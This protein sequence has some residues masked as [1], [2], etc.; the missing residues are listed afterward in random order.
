MADD[1]VRAE[2]YRHRAAVIRS[3]ARRALTIETK[4][5]LAALADS[6]EKLADRVEAR[7]LV[8]AAEHGDVTHIEDGG[9]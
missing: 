6:F 8:H 9:I 2:W 1:L 4:L 3:I 5:N 7:E